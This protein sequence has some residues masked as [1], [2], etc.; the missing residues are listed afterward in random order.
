V[1]VLVI[2]GSRARLPDPVYPLGAAMVATVL[3]R[4]GHEVHCFDALRHDEPATALCAVLDGLAPGAV[5]LSIRNID[6]AAFPGVLRH[7]E[8]HLGLARAVT[9]WGRAPLVLGGS[10]FSLMPEAFLAYLGADCGVAGAGEEAVPELIAALE[11]GRTPPRL[12]RAGRVPPPFTAVDRALFDADWYYGSGGVANLQTQRG[13]SLTCVYCTYPLLEGHCP[14][15]AEPGAVADEL[16]ALSASG[17][18]HVFIVDAVFNRPEAHAAAVCEEIVRRG[19]DLS[20]TGYFVPCGELP[21]LPALLKRAGFDA[22]ELGTD[23]LSDPTL[24]GMRKG[25]TAEQAMD[26]SRR[27]GAAGIKQCHNLIFGGPGETVET[28]AESVRRMDELRPTAMIAT[29]G[30]RV[31]PGTDL[32]GLAGGPRAAGDDPRAVLEPVFYV[33]DAVA[34][35]IVERVGSLVDARQNWICPGLDR[36]YNPRYLE[37]LRK[38]RKGLLWAMFGD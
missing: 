3:A 1:R 2:S 36:R 32:E 13:C 6:S 10:G 38:R 34:E 11:Q 29:I 23:S 12:I 9:E 15:G 22:V 17:I 25:F 26:F 27:L 35:T 5:L 28:M 21:E 14:R 37:R 8:E 7:F 31:Y 16:A 24:A 30:L 19:L 4:A 33:E 20:L 18:R